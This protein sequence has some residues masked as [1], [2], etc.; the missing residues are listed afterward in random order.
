MRALPLRRRQIER[1]RCLVTVQRG[2]E[3]TRI[4]FYLCI[5]SRTWRSDLSL[6]SFKKKKEGE[7]KKRKVHDDTFSTI[8]NKT[9]EGM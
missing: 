8:V 7:K 5:V 1:D 6:R 9:G 3:T 2:Q 4:F